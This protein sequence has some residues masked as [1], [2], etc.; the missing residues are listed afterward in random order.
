M[1]VRVHA[2][3]VPAAHDLAHE[4]G[5]RLGLLADDEEGGLGPVRVE[6]VDADNPELVRFSV[7]D[8]GVGIDPAVQAKI[9]E[10]TP[11]SDRATYADAMPSTTSSGKGPRSTLHA[12]TTSTAAV[13]AR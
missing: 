11:R 9:F 3:G 6:R 5:V 4:L 2:H 12:G 7:S 8:T 1:R 13:E 10:N